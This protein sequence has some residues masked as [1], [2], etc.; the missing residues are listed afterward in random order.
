MI[1]SLSSRPPTR[2]AVGTFGLVLV[3]IVE[4]GG[5]GGGVGGGSVFLEG[6]ERFDF[7]GVED[8]EDSEGFDGLIASR[9][10]LWEA[11]I[12]GVD[13]IQQIR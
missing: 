9:K 4:G 12:D 10:A 1:P 5:D 7:D 2:G 13:G 6:S 3:D 11:F 8:D